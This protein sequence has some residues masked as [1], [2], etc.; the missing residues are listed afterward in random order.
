MTFRA[1]ARW[2][3]VGVSCIAVA[4]GGDSTSPRTAPPAAV[5]ALTELTQS[6]DAGSQLPGVLSVE[7]TDAAGRPVSNATVTFTTT[8]G[9]GAAMP[10]V[11]TTN[12]SG[13]AT[14]SWALGTIAGANE[15]TVSVAGLADQLHYDATGAPGPVSGVVVAPA[16]TRVLVGQNTTLIAAHSV[17]VY[18]NVTTPAPTFTV[19][20]PS[21]LGVDS[22][23]NVQ[24]LRRGAGTYVVA[25]AGGKSD[26]TLVTVL[27]VGESICT[28]AASPVDLAVGQVLT[29]VSGDGFCVHASTDD[30]E[31]ALI[32]YFNS[33]TPGE[34][35]QLAVTGQ[36]LS[37]L[38]APSASIFD[39]RPIAPTAPRLVPD[40][41]FENDLRARERLQMPP[42]LA[43]AREWYR[44]QRSTSGAPA[45]AAL[46]ATPAIGTLLHLNA[47]GTDF[48]DNPDV[49]TGRVVAITNGAIVVADTAN[50]TG[51]FT[52][53]E[54]Q[55]IGVTFDTLVNPVDTAAFG[56]PSDID[57][58]GHV[59]LFFTRAVNE[60]T[61]AGAG[62]VVLGFFYKRDL[63]PT[64]SAAG[65]CPGSNVGEMFYLLVPDTGGVINSNKR[66]K[67][68]VV[69]FTNGT[70]A[71]EYQ[72][73]INASRRMYVNDAPGFE[74]PWLDEG[75]AHTAEELNFFRASGTS[76]RAN[77]DAGAFADPRF[78]DAFATFELNNF[79]RY[80]TYLQS[81]ESQ[82]P[83]GV[84]ATDDDL[85][86]RGAI[87]DFLRYVAD[88]QAPNT[89]QQLWHDL[90]N[91]RTSGIANLTQV[92]G[93]APN[94]LLRD[95]VISVY[96]DDNAPG[97][98][99]RFQQPTWNMRSAIP[100]GGAAST[101][102]L[103]SRPL[104]DNLT[105]SVLLAGASGSFMRFAVANGADALLTVTA[106]NQALPAAVQLAV[107]RVR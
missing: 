71:H 50:P 35:I 86:T 73:L 25:S 9:N 18:G 34:R 67:A 76:P 38:A 51:G 2:S 88:H 32:P 97:V 66:S 45:S 94:G 80:V 99:A 68:Q 78:A 33:T 74:E 5:A 40:A 55:S 102:A 62:S 100:A 106:A 6:G 61:S 64:T 43:A 57:H 41:R 47:N 59:I 14:A 24:A 42:R 75:L 107:V 79:R 77:F 8:A 95:W 37:T 70:V 20:D 91:S 54:Y 56:A 15:I 48:C 63:L 21:L 36:G 1:P 83:I 28:G 39:R 87:W 31:Y 105:S 16:R 60:L 26:S 29:D 44:A 27:D 23:G 92:L 11:V 89:E 58:N 49:R 72:H 85:P 104:A 17:D 96:M 4:C 93:Q 90:V 82:G 30:A 19:R 84:D 103:A 13:Q 46:A 53:S 10:H 65:N 52:E 81:P 22:S 98:D 3:I 12:S 7:V 69:S 101:F